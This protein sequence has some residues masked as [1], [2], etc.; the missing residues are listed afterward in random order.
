MAKA[1]QT[2]TTNVSNIDAANDLIIDGRV[3][4]DIE[5][6]NSIRGLMAEYNVSLNDLVDL[7]I[8]S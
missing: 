3:I 6:A 5:T 2:Q 1:T 8:I 7:G 4:A